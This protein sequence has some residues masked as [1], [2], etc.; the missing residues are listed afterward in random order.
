MTVPLL[1]VEEV[2]ILGN[3]TISTP[4]LASLLEAKVQI[5]Y[6]TKYGHYLGSL[7]PI[8]TKNSILRLA[9]HEAHKDAAKRHAIAQRFVTGKLRNM[10][11][12]LMRYQRQHSDPLFEAQIESVTSPP[13]KR[14]GLPTLTSRHSCF[15]GSCAQITMLPG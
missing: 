4:A 11:T 1:K 5:S 3:I 8:L 9:Q 6:L 10:R 12:I 13:L 15:R 14:R 7:S 2:V